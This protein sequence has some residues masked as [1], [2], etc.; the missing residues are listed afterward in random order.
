VADFNVVKGFLN[1]SLSQRYWAN[2]LNNILVDVNYGTR[3]EGTSGKTYMVEYS[4]PNTNKPC[5]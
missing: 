4:S 3:P 1:I 5:I 2:F